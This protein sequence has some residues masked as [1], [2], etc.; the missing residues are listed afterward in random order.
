MS[1]LIPISTSTGL[2]KR[3]QSPGAR[4]LESIRPMAKLAAQVHRLRAWAQTVP[5]VELADCCSYPE[6]KIV[7]ILSRLPREDCAEVRE[8]DELLETL[9]SEDEAATLIGVYADSLQRSAGQS[10]LAEVGMAV[11]LVTAQDIFVEV[12]VERE[13]LE[14][15]HYT[16]K[17][18]QHRGIISRQ[19]LAAA[20]ERLATAQKSTPFG[21]G[22]SGDVLASAM[23][24]RK[25]F[26]AS[27]HR[28][29]GIWRRDE[30]EAALQL[31]Q[32]EKL[33]PEQVEGEGRWLK[34]YFSE[35]RKKDWDATFEEILE[36]AHQKARER[37]RR[38]KARE[39]ER[40]ITNALSIISTP[41]VKSGVTKRMQR[42][43]EET[44]VREG[45]YAN[46][47]SGPFK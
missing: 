3:E 35:E 14:G 1:N 7:E 34:Y 41:T 43:A 6:E 24:V 44:L 16:A 45:Y 17:Q 22:I 30:L 11:H 19:I 15:V 33:V 32:E 27:Y 42:E 37:F 26:E 5:L 47:A 38:D 21:R 9:V 25:Q 31:R 12:E 10:V 8:F 13:T 29:R 2:T 46:H 20:L 40:A 18:N 23:Y 28:I 36:L 39:R 4:A